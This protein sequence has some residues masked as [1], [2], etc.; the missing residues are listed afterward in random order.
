MKFERETDKAFVP[1]AITL[2]SEEELEVVTEILGMSTDAIV[3]NCDLRDANM[4]RRA[5]NKQGDWKQRQKFNMSRAYAPIIAEC[6]TL[7][8]EEKNIS[9]DEEFIN[10]TDEKGEK[11]GEK[12]I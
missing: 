5:L 11:N 2:E 6:L 12:G 9:D 10:S 1:I 8:F 7:F 3:S 4:I